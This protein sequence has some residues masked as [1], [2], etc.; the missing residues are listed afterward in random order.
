[1]VVTND[2]EPMTSPKKVWRLREHEVHLVRQ[3]IEIVSVG[4]NPDG[5]FE[6]L[7]RNNNS[8]GTLPTLPILDATRD[9]PALGPWFKRL[10]EYVCTS[11][12]T[13]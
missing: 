12:R 2:K 11:G 1:M 6:D 3:K 13:A 4:V 9:E 10:L 5:C 7:R 8:N